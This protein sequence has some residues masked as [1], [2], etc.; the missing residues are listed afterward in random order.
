MKQEVCCFSIYS[1]QEVQPS[2]WQEAAPE[3]S[4]LRGVYSGS[5]PRKSADCWQRPAN[6]CRGKKSQKTHGGRRH[7]IDSDFSLHHRLVNNLDMEVVVFKDYGKEYIKKLRMSPDA[8]V[9]V[10]LQLAFYK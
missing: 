7:Y 9:Q 10:A 4:P 3:S 2:L 6:D 8:F 5:A 1:D